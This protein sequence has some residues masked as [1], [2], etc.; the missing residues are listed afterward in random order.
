ML[1]QRSSMGALDAIEH[2]VGMQAQAPFAPYYG[3]WSRLD[4]FT[5]E[6]L[7]DLLTTRKAVRIV[8]MRGTI[9]LVTAKDCH[10]LRPLVQP[11]LDR[12]LRGNTTHGK[13]LAAVDLSAVVDAAERLLDAE[14]LTPGEVGARLAEKWPDTPPGSLAEAARSKLPL[15]QVPPR[16]LWQRSG[17][18]RLTTATAWLGKPRGKLPTIDDL[19]MRYLAAFGP[20]SAA[21]VQ[22][23]SGLTRLGEV[24]ERM[25]VVQLKSEGGQTLYDVPNA[26]RPD[27]DVPAPVRLVAPFDNILLSH[28]DRTRVISDDHRK[29]LF[30][31][32]NG[33]FPGTVLV[34][35]F[36]SGTWE[37][38]G[39]GEETSLRVQPYRRL[40]VAEEVI[41]EGNRLLQLAF[42]VTQPRVDVIR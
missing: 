23:W 32:K 11:A 8:L 34:D 6:Q 24:L 30:A 27:P 25:K 39:K 5:G 14:Q 1:L 38:V 12:M 10:R 9:H 35:G 16:A 40:D 31:G 7:S 21:D 26:P 36:V 18:V 28:A 37:L 19:L 13:A 42:G 17:Q 22:T 15:V 29:R 33:V 4:G 3:L 20:A 41:R 2:L